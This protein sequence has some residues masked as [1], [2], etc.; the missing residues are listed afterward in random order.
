MRAWFIPLLYKWTKIYRTMQ[1]NYQSQTSSYLPFSHNRMRTPPKCCFWTKN[2]YYA[3][4][5]TTKHTL[6]PSS[7][8]TILKNS[9]IKISIDLKY[10]CTSQKNARLVYIDKQCAYDANVMIL[11]IWLLNHE[12]VDVVHVIFQL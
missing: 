2:A 8:I 9:S 7:I 12:G 5:V 4:L 11:F 6:H 1:R 3:W 10:F